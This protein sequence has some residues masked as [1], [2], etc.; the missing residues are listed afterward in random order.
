MAGVRAAQT[1]HK[2]VFKKGKKGGDL[3]LWVESIL[4]FGFR[5]QKRGCDQKWARGTFPTSKNNEMGFP[6]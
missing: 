3:H 1:S 6:L 4:W 2:G 5:T